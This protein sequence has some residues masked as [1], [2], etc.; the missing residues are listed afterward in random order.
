MT[1]IKLSMSVEE[2]RE[3]GARVKVI[4]RSKFRACLEGKSIL[5]GKNVVEEYQ[6]MRVWQE[7]PVVLSA[8]LVSQKYREIFPGGVQEKSNASAAK[9][10][11]ALSVKE[12]KTL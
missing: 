12:T 4:S 2:S 7:M 11:S 6:E 5:P 10:R 9:L 3:Q 1:L 8:S